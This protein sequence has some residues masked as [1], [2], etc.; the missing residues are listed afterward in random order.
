MQKNTFAA[1][2]L[3]ALYMKDFEQC[4]ED[5]WLAI[6]PVDL[7]VEPT[8]L[9]AM[10]QLPE[11]AM[12]YDAE[13]ALLGITPTYNAPQYGY[14]E[15]AS[16]KVEPQICYIQQFNEKPS[17][18]VA[19]QLIHQGALWNSGVFVFQIKT[20]LQVLREFS[21]PLHYE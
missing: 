13:M 14:I 2:Y 4:M 12:Q 5:E 6:V 7:L 19:K 18:E 16:E 8:F 17:T 9:Q 15:T 20:L 10:Q 21:L 1:V 11:K 3:A